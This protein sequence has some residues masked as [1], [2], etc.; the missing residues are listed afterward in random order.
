MVTSAEALAYLAEA[1]STPAYGAPGNDFDL[2]GLREG[3]AQRLAPTDT[4]VTCRPVAADSIPCQWILAPGCDPD[5]RLLYLHGGGFVSGAGDH[6]AALA[7]KVS[8][9]AGCAVLMA[10][11]RLAPEHPFPAGLQDCLSAYRWLLHN[12]P[13]RA[14]PARAVFIAG[15]SA[16][17]GLVLS[18][19]L[20]LRDQA[21]EL[22]AAGIALSPFADLTLTGPSIISENGSDPIMSAECLPVFVD[23]YLAGSDPQD[24]LAS[25]VFG[26]FSGL[27]PLLLQVGQFEVIR[28]DCVRVAE[29][30]QAAGVDVALEVWPDMVHVFQVRELPESQQAIERIA[31]F[32]RLLMPLP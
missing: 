21:E 28:D 14:T 22:P 17:G 9:A 15:D 5:V 23:L 8:A 16:G 26:D 25:P 20:A 1:R 18:A 4:A 12:G 24:A 2:A 29:R 32:M 11:Y 6:Y 27:P 19:L 3:M 30:A 10:D 13:E 31:E 7:A